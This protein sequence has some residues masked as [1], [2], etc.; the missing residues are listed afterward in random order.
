MA[1]PPHV[2][3][4]IGGRRRQP[5]VHRLLL[6]WRLIIVIVSTVFVTAREQMLPSPPRPHCYTSSDTGFITVVAPIGPPRSLAHVFSNFYGEV[7][8]FPLAF[9]DDALPFCALL[10]LQNHLLDDFSNVNVLAQFVSQMKSRLPIATVSHILCSLLSAQRPLQFPSTISYI[11]FLYIG[12][13][14]LVTCPYGHQGPKQLV[15]HGVHSLF[16][17]FPFLKV[18]HK[19]ASV[20]TKAPF[21]ETPPW[22]RFL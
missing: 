21:Y 11:G 13:S 6:P 17:L 18:P 2:V 7:A 5:N 9:L 20:E 1:P 3:T 4:K 8:Q 12:G 16:N 15:S 22:L 10:F 14:I 19:M